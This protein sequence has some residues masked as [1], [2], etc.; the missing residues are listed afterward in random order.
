MYESSRLRH[1][2]VAPE[3]SRFSAISPPMP[4]PVDAIL[5][6]THSPIATSRSK[7]LGQQ[8]RLIFNPIEKHWLGPKPPPWGSLSPLLGEG[9]SALKFGDSGGG[10]LAF[11]VSPRA[12]A[13]CPACGLLSYLLATW[14]SGFLDRHHG[15]DRNSY[16]RGSQSDDAVELRLENNTVAGSGT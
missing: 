15:C 16:W 14:T 8:P 2:H 11:G 4:Y 7:P 12:S 10:A 9:V 5:G 6:N 1:Q 3:P 13:A